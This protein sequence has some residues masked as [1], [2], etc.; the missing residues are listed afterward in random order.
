MGGLL[1][2]GCVK[3][4][5]EWGKAHIRVIDSVKIREMNIFNTH[6]FLHKEGN[7][8]KNDPQNDFTASSTRSVQKRSTKSVKHE[9]LM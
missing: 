4:Y 8:K 2:A 3:K 1:S 7:N 6:N 9:T 5:S